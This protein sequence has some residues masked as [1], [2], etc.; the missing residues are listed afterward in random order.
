MLRA[1]AMIVLTLVFSKTFRAFRAIAISGY[2]DFGHGDVDGNSD[3]YSRDDTMK[4][5]ET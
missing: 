2:R 5:V 4:E 1:E 3:A